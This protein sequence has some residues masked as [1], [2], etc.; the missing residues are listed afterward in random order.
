MSQ[1][2]RM[3]VECHKVEE[4]KLNVTGLKNES[5]MSQGWRMKVECHKGED[6]KFKIEIVNLVRIRQKAKNWKMSA[7]MHPAV[8]VLF[9]TYQVRKVFA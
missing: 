2:W 6:W 1:G 4:W 9:K 7:C 3:K 8:T 5:W